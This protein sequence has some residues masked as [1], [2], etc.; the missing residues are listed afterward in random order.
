MKK[1]ILLIQLIFIFT[2]GYT[3]YRYELKVI[4]KLPKGTKLYFNILD[5]IEWKL[6]KKDSAIINGDYIKFNGTFTQPAHYA[7]LLIKYKGRYISE[8]FV[9]DSGKNS[10]SLALKLDSKTT[11]DRVTIGTKSNEIYDKLIAI[12]IQQNISPSSIR[13]MASVLQNYPNEYFSVLALYQLTHYDRT[14]DYAKVTL[15]TLSLLNEDL[16]NSPLGQEIFREQSKLISNL[17]SVKVGKAVPYF[18][19]K[20]D[21]GKLFQNESLKGKP[22]LIVFSATWCAP[23]QKQL[24]LLK[25]VY[26]KY[27]PEGLKVVYFNNDSD[28]KRWKEH[29]LKNKLTWIN[30]S[31]R[32][33]P[34]ESKIQKSFGVYAVP[35]CLLIDKEGKIVY[36]SDQDDTGLTKLDDNVKRTVKDT[37]R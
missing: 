36:N 28:V 29:I 7:A 2:T 26:E 11:L 4:S 13:E 35:T 1:I 9:I 8:N 34:T 24:P 17:E 16:Q 12:K 37:S 25:Q 23:C 30:V 5:N 22:Y 32:L 33:K 18:S 10:L 20:D 6:I 15:N 31:E 14:E 3:Q 27:K 19:V 21:N